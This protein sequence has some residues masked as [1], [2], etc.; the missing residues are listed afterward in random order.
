MGRVSGQGRH[1]EL[2]LSW[3]DDSGHTWSHE[4]RLAAGP[5]G[6]YGQ[7]ALWRRLGRSRYRVY[8]VVVSDPVKW[9]FVDAYLSVRKGTA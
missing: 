6:E 8:R 7:R 2:I 9:A 4:H 3:S 1:P 5:I